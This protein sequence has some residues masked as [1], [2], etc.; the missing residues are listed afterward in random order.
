MVFPPPRQRQ[1][2]RSMAPIP[3]QPFGNQPGNSRGVGGA[4]NARGITGLLSSFGGQSAG[5]LGSAATGG[6]Q[7]LSK[8]LGGLQQ[9][10]GIVQS[11]APLIQEYG[12]MIKNLPS[13]YRMMKAFK[14]ISNEDEELDESTDK[15]QES[16]AKSEVITEQKTIEPTDS[17][18]S[19]PA[20]SESHSKEKPETTKRQGISTPKLYI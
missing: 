12:P 1:G 2:Q 15:K 11:T 9:F 17:I 10:L 3:R 20:E 7:T 18:K 16:I 4:S 5:G 19:E 14:E 6:L 13:M 8:S